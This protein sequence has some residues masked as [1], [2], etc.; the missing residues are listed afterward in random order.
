[1]T[2]SSQQRRWTIG[3][4]SCQKAE[5][6]IFDRR[7]T[8]LINYANLDNLICYV[9][10]NCANAEIGEYLVN[11]SCIYNKLNHAEDIKM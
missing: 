3:N 2:N 5:D 1:V 4:Y 6:A 11:K 9:F 7:R 8:F 10:Q